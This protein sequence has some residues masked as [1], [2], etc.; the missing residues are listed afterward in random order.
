MSVSLIGRLFVCTTHLAMYV[1]NDHGTFNGK[2]FF[3]A[4]PFTDV[5]R[6]Q[7]GTKFMMRVVTSLQTSYIFG[8][9][10]SETHFGGAL[11]L[12]EH[13]IEAK[14]PSTEDGNAE[15]V[16]AAKAAVEVVP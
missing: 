8:D 7:K 15:A 9:F 6:V 16:G 5:V 12:V 14:V 3:V 11:S 1:F 2:K 10:E 13:M 4:I